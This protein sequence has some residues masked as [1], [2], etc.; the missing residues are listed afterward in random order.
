MEISGLE[1][2]SCDYNSS[3]ISSGFYQG[4]GTNSDVISLDNGTNTLPNPIFDFKLRFRFNSDCTIPSITIKLGFGHILQSPSIDI[5]NDGIID[6][7]VEK[8]WLGTYGFQSFFFTGQSSSGNF[9]RESLIE[10]DAVSGQTTGGFILIPQNA[11]IEHFDLDFS[12]NTIYDTTDISK[13]FQMNITTGITSV[14]L[15]NINRETNFNLLDK[16]TAVRL[17]QPI[18]DLLSDPNTPVFLSDEYGMNWIRV[19]FEINQENANDGASVLLNSL[20]V[21]YKHT[22]TLD[23]DSGFESSL[24]EFVAK[25]LGSSQG[26]NLLEIPVTST[27][28]SGGV[29]HL[30]NLTILTEPGY[31]STLNWNSPSQGLYANGQIY[32]IITTHEVEQ[33]TGSTLADGRLRFVFNETTFYLNYNN[34]KLRLRNLAMR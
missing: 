2:T 23:K 28:I 9:A 21:I 20:K 33:S 7:A 5:F 27:G 19:A 26:S 22:Y 16:V 31:S 1:R 4:Q 13:G 10:I 17:Y 24:R 30:S 11:Q 34:L 18:N 6:W 14:N 8:P 29:I 12:Q 25:N 32:E 3:L 15:G